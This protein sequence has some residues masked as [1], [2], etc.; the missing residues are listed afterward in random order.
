MAWA[1]IASANAPTSGVFDFPSLTLTGVKVLRV[2]LSEIAV[3][4]DGTDIALTF[5]I[6]G[7]EVVA[8]Y[9]WGFYAITSAGSPNQDGDS[10]DP[11]ILLVSND[12]NWD[13][14]NAAAE[15]WHGI[16]TV[17]NP[18]STALHKRVTLE[19]SGIGPTG[20]SVG[21]FGGGMLSNAGPIQGLKI[22]GTSNLTAGKVRI[23]GLA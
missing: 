6:A 12:A 5:Y 13:V 17:F 1:A 18:I 2:H 4:T 9:Q 21:S 7:S 16:V 11:S 15:S 3:T 19:G 10:S 22:G 14:G 20:I 23:L 8:G